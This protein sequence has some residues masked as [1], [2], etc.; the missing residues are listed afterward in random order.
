MS[1]LRE[2]KNLL[3]EEMDLII[4]TTSALIRRIQPEQWDYKP[5]QQMR[6]L[7][8]LVQ[9][10]VLVPAVDLLIL[11]ENAAE[12]IRGVEKTYEELTDAEK[13]V[14]L[15]EQGTA[16]L[17]KYMDSLTDD[18]FLHH[19]TRPFYH[20]YGSVQAKWLIEI[21]THAQHHRAQLFTYLKQLGHEVTMFDLY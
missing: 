8:E 17:K 20:E 9:H 1:D 13:L 19:S 7:K 2:M 6:S 4:R 21:V 18:Q 5:V 16:D 3:Y 15:L 14:S 11:Q 10:L 12:V